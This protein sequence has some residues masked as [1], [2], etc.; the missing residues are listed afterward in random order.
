MTLV[1]LEII[2]SGIVLVEAFLMIRSKTRRGEVIFAALIIGEFFFMGAFFAVLLSM[3][4]ALGGGG[5]KEFNF[6]GFL[7]GL[8]I[9]GGLIG[10]MGVGGI[11]AVKHLVLRIVKAYTAKRVNKP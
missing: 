7:I 8:G 10:A 6:Y 4:A 1:I 3:G 2:F 11:W 5:S 9:I